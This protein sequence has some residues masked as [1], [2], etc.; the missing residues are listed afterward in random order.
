MGKAYCKAVPDCSQTEGLCV[1]HESPI[2][3][4]VPSAAYAVMILPKEALESQ[5]RQE[6]QGR[7]VTGIPTLTLGILLGFGWW[8]RSGRTL[9]PDCWEQGAGASKHAVISYCA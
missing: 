6:S 5:G 3:S 4:A 8:A 1:G 9:A 2:P 7:G